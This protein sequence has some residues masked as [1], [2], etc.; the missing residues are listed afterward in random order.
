MLAG[1]RLTGDQSIETM[2]KYSILTRPLWEAL[3]VDSA[4]NV[5]LPKTAAYARYL[6]SAIELTMLYERSLSSYYSR[7]EVNSPFFLSVSI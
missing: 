3:N 2:K 4:L 1:C 7:Y 6:L 5:K